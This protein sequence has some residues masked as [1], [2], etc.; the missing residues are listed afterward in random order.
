MKDFHR[1]HSSRY[2]RFRGI[3]HGFSAI[4]LF[5]FF[6]NRAD[7]L[8]NPLLRNSF[9]ALDPKWS[10]V[11]GSH[12]GLSHREVIHRRIV[13]IS[14]NSSNSVNGSDPNSLIVNDPSFCTGLLDHLGY[15]SQC[16]FLKKAPAVFFG[17][18]V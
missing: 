13:E 14:A 2:S 17:R 1:F 7:V 9:S 3:F 16:E 6:Y 11:V 8:R 5:L 18:T 10:S 15:E 4:V 12:G